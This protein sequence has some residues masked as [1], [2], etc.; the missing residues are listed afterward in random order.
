MPSQP[1]PSLSLSKRSPCTELC[2]PQPLRALSAAAS[3]PGHLQPVLSKGIKSPQHI[4][5]VFPAQ[6]TQSSLSQLQNSCFCPGRESQTLTKSR[7]CCRA[8]TLCLQ[9]HQSWLVREINPQAQNPLGFWDLGTWDQWQRSMKS[10]QEDNPG[11][12][13]LHHLPTA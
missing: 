10:T 8:P 11:N 13:A 2:L 1:G 3:Q 6:G 5:G 7:G 4:P 12:L 9:G